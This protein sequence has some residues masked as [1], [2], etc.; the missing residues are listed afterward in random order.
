MLPLEEALLKYRVAVDTKNAIDPD[1]QIVARCDA[2]TA[3]NSR[4]VP[5]AIERMRAYKDVGVDVLYLEGPRS[6]DEIEQVRAHVDGPLMCIG[7]NLPNQP[8]VQE[9]ADLG[10]AAIIGG[11][12][13]RR[14]ESF[15]RAMIKAFFEQG[16][17]VLAK[18]DAMIPDHEFVPVRGM[19]EEEEWGRE[20]E[21]KYLSAASLQKYEG[22]PLDTRPTS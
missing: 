19:S 3:S 5:E 14:L 11:P 8:T 21:R 13:S 2:L 17:E 6:F 15:R 12:S 10:I 1:F 18:F 7:Y 9:M 4:G 20:F 16:P 22:V